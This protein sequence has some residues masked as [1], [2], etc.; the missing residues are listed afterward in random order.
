MVKLH[1]ITQ[2]NSRILPLNLYGII[3]IQPPK[4]RGSYVSPFLSPQDTDK[5]SSYGETMHHG[6]ASHPAVRFHRIE[7]MNSR[8]VFTVKG[9]RKGERKVQY[10]S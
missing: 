8:L 2:R 7:L 1:H 5:Q 9:E 6:E 4:E 3:Y 10:G